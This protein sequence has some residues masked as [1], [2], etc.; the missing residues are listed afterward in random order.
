[1]RII[2][3]LA[4]LSLVT[5]ACGLRF[6]VPANNKK[7][8]KEEIHKNIV[9]TGEYEFSEGI[10]YTGS[11]HVTDT[12]GHTL[13]KREKFSDLKGKFAFTADEYD[14]FEI[15]I[16]NHA[17]ATAGPDHDCAQNSKDPYTDHKSSLWDRIGGLIRASAVEIGRQTE[18]GRWP[19]NELSSLGVSSATLR[20]QCFDEETSQ[21]IRAAGIKCPQLKSLELEYLMPKEYR[22][23]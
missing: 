11:V 12:R 7:C 21:V 5:I 19:R 20:F 9:V 15:C 13:Y 18:N 2:T 17:P 22:I 3:S 4:L 8:M 16:S 1:M 23:K 10:G 6:N 14:I